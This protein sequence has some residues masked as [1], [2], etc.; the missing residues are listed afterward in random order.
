M[1]RPKP[2]RSNRSPFP[3]RNQNAPGRAYHMR[4]PS[5]VHDRS[6]TLPGDTWSNGRLYELTAAVLTSAA[7]YCW[8][9]RPMRNRTVRFVRPVANCKVS[10]NTEVDRRRNGW[11]GVLRVLTS[12][13]LG[14]VTKH[15]YYRASKDATPR[16]PTSARPTNEQPLLRPSAGIKCAGH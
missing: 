5:R 14:V 8:T 11:S 2:R 1:P 6:T 10:L 13:F 9:C 12:R 7:E 4:F 15:D 16:V 3:G